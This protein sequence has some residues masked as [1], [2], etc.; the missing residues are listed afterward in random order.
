MD[1]TMQT[2]GDVGLGCKTLHY[3]SPMSPAAWTM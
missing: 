1:L 3:P 2:K